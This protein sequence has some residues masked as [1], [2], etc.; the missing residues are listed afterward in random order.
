[1]D[2]VFAKIVG[3]AGHPG[4][5]HR[6]DPDP[7]RIS[8]DPS[9]SK[10]PYKIYN[11]GNNNPVELLDYIA[12]I[13]EILEKKAE[14]NYL[15]MQPGDVA[16]TWADVDDLVKDLDYKPNTSIKEGIMKFVEWY[17]WYYKV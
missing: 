10:A 14:R 12:T 15:P 6:N 1:M 2:N 16:R 4:G 9:S 3:E 13:E 7:Y 5:G 11:I 8:P 17:R